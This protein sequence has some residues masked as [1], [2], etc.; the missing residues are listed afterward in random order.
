MLNPI[1]HAR[2]EKDFARYKVEPYVIAADVYALKG[3][4]GRAGEVR[5]LA[6]VRL[7]S[8]GDA[9]GPGRS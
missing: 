3:H 2:A 5:A 4:I 1:E 9:P 6:R 7:A 8:A